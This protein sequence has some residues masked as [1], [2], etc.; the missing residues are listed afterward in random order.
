M[1]TRKGSISVKT[2][3]IFPIIKKW[4]YSEHDIFIRELVSNACD[5]ITKRSTL[6]RSEGH[7]T[8]AGKV[9]ILLNK[10]A[11]T[12]TISDNG[13]GMN[14][15]EVEKYIAQLAFSGAEEFVQKMKTMGNNTAKDEIIGKF[16]LGFYSA[17]MV[18]AK[19]EVES[20]SMQ[21]GSKPTKW[22]CLGDTEYEFSESTKSEVGTTITLHIAEDS[23]DFLDKWKFN[24]TLTRYC[25]FMP[26]PIG[27]M[28]L[29]NKEATEEIINET[30]P[31]WKKD[32][33]TLKDE[34]YKEFYRKMFPMDPEPLFWLHLNV[35]HPFTL[36]GVLF[37][38]KLN[39]SKP[40]QEN[41]IQLYSKQVFVSDSVKNI[42]PDFLGLLKGA[43]D[44]V[45]I[46][47]NVSRSS[48]QGDPNIKKISNYI[49]KKV[50]ESLKKL[51]NSDRERYEKAWEDIGLFVKYGCMQDEKFD[52]VMRKFVLFK[53]TD[54]KLVTLEDYQASVPEAYKE[55]LKDK[56]VYFEKNLSD[57]SLR[58][59]LQ[60][61]GIQVLETDQ[62]I[63]PHFMQHCE[64]K[65]VGEQ[66]FKFASIDSEIENLLEATDTHADDIKIK[67]FFKQVLVG[68]NK[69]KEMTLDVDVKSLKN[70]SSS[71]YFKVDE[72]MKRFQQMTK[73][74]GNSAFSMPVK[75]TLV[76]N[77]RNTLIKNALKIWEKGEKKEL[78]EKIVHHVQDLASLSSEGL[79]SED[80]EKF[81]SRS[82]S[83]VQELSQFI[84]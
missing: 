64:M 84:V 71:A 83:L 67:D 58:K 15:S 44:S 29:S 46:P 36:Q 16:G 34:D 80:K 25:S 13:L 60:A 32:P 4:L 23:L 50:S 19:V 30:T 40:I 45:D 75:K 1:T 76:V 11:K 28:D 65:K 14:E 18:A 39:Q 26:Y 68:D 22:T 56:Y 21:P 72:Q 35:D 12:I 62:Y 81:V 78:A 9:S 7:E 8:P 51:F 31:L 82:Q 37:F 17:F 63:D 70:A 27:L 52:E 42:V 79:T 53:N 2:N 74:M 33:T 77:P 48:L 41:G 6:A 66:T 54:G 57:E 20:L 38:P 3:D 73:S 59:Q 47:L 49:I 55:K 69:E 10:E 24:E 61:E 43:I 5:A